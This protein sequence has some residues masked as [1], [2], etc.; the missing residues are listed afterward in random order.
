[1]PFNP[2]DTHPFQNLNRLFTWYY[3]VSLFPFKLAFKFVLTIGI[4]A[5]SDGFINGLKQQQL[6]L[7]RR[8]QLFT[9]ANPADLM[10]VVKNFKSRVMFVV[11]VLI[12]G[13]QYYWLCILCLLLFNNKDTGYEAHVL[14]QI[15]ERH[16]IV[17]KIDFSI[18]KGD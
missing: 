6:A 18:A 9:T 11:F 2:I 3:P 4:S 14:S 1:M 5:R 12:C 8:R 16:E 15:R 7:T 17:Q 10:T 13:F